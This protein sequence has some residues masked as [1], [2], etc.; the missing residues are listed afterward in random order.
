[1][2]HYL[3]AAANFGGVICW[4]YLGYLL[5]VA[6]ND[7]GLI[8]QLAAALLTITLILRLI[9]D[10]LSELRDAAIARLARDIAAHRANMEP[11][12]V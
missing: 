11:P 8:L 9:N 5:W 10:A 1:M 12:N 6:L 7:D 2:K 3:W 4:L